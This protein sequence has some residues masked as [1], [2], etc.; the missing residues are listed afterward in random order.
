MELMKH[1]LEGYLLPTDRGEEPNEYD[2][3]MMEKDSNPVKNFSWSHDDG[4]PIA[5]CPPVD[6]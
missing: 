5:K 6:K 3:K 4:L 1:I 2:L